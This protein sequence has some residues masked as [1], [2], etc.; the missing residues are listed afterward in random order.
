MTSLLWITKTNAWHRWLIITTGFILLLM[1]VL[2]AVLACPHVGW[3]S[4][5]LVG[6]VFV[7]T[8]PVN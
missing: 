6:S 2:L 5:L 3:V 1:T 8:L 4:L 7:F